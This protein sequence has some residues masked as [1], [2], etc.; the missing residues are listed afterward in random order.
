MRN[1]FALGYMSLVYCS[2]VTVIIMLF[3]NPRSICPHDVTGLFHAKNMKKCIYNKINS[4]Q[5]GGNLH[6]CLRLEI[7]LFQSINLY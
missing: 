3:L 4:V 1:I 2:F 7:S 5:C 6:L